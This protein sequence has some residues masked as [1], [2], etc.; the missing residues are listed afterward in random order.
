MPKLFLLRVS[1][2]FRLVPASEAEYRFTSFF[3]NQFCFGL[4]SKHNNRS[5]GNFG[6]ATALDHHATLDRGD[7]FRH[8][9]TLG[10]GGYSTVMKRHRENVMRFLIFAGHAR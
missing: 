1:G 3:F 8:D 10:H 4:E 5:Q 6:H 2:A 7:T 9:E